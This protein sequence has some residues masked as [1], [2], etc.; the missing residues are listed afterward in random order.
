MLFNIFLV[1]IIISFIVR[2]LRVC[3]Y[4]LYIWQLKEYRLDRYFS[5]LKTQSGKKLLFSPFS[6]IKWLLLVLIYGSSLY[7]IVIYSFYA[8]WLIWILELLLFVKDLFL[9]KLRF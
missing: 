5:F 6:N 4:H 8:F 1:I 3:F 2:T 7:N 9:K